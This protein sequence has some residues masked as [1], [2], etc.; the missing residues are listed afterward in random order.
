MASAPNPHRTIGNARDIAD[1]FLPLFEGAGE[2]R[3]LVAHLRGDR[4][5]ELVAGAKGG[6][7]DVELPIR[8]IIADALRLDSDGLVVGHN[9]PGGDPMP[10][11]QDRQATRLLAMTTESLGIRLVDHLIWGD[12]RWSSF[13]ALGLL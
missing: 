4:L 8:A 2:E 12:G 13:R 6:R 3:V 10:S 9:H 5:I 1:L 11:E 7:E